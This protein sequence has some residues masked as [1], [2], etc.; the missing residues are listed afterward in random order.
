MPH[1]PR[2]LP[3]YGNLPGQF[4]YYF[5]EDLGLG[6]GPVAFAPA[7]IPPLADQSHPQ[8]EGR[9]GGR[10]RAQRPRSQARRYDAG[11]AG[12]RAPVARV[13]LRGQRGWPRRRRWPAPGP[14]PRR[15]Q[16]VIDEMAQ[17]SKAD[18]ASNYIVNVRPCYVDIFCG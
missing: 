2:A 15:R 1:P 11:V 18:I 17:R 13:R 12:V 9:D 10:V 8:G 3:E 6:R 7:S 16:H 4:N 5:E 14:C